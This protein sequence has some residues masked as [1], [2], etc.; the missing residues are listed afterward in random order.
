MDEIVETAW[1]HAADRSEGDAVHPRHR[2]G[3]RG[4]EAEVRLRLPQSEREGPL[5]LRRILPRLKRGASRGW[6]LCSGARQGRRDRR[7]LVLSRAGDRPRAVLP[8]LRRGAAAGPARSL[9]AAGP[10]ALSSWMRRSRPALFRLPAQS[11]SRSL[12]AAR[13]KER[14]IAE[15]QAASLNEAYRNAEGSAGARRLSARARRHPQRRR[16][17]GKTIDDRGT[18]DGGDGDPRGADGGGDRSRPSTR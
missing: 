18:A 12:R 3:L 9:R 15:S 11:A 2:D 17:C 1:R 5:R 7:L 6:H 10:A 16:R 13:A 4:G 8:H 14:A